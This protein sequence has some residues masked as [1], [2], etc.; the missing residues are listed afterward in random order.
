MRKSSSALVTYSSSEED[1]EAEVQRPPKKRKLPPLASSLLTP[2]PIDRPELHQGRIRTTPHVEGQ[3]AAHVY[4]SLDVAKRSA[5]YEFMDDVL[6]HAK[7][8]CPTLN[9]IW[10]N[11]ESR[12]RRELHISLSRPIYLRT[13]QREELKNAVKEFS[14]RF[15]PFRVSFATFC[16]LVNDERTR[17]FL[18]MEVGA[19][20]NELR[21][22]SD[23]LTPTL[24]VLRQKEFY[25]DPRFHASIAWALLDGVASRQSPSLAIADADSTTADPSLAIL[26]SASDCLKPVAEPAFPT[27][28][29]LPE[30]LVPSL[31]RQYAAKLASPK[32][33]VYDVDAITVKIG[34]DIHTWPLSG[35]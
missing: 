31:I 7:K 21:T 14:K 34:K 8:T 26:P 17:T 33:G 9:D 24:Q 28:P 1:L 20:H 15:S 32:T 3:W 25:S 2:A 13:H 10:T 23:A 18:A 27:I 11:S 29:H 4:V 30:D 19:G 35:V 16:E 6:A 12:K 22:I 5:L